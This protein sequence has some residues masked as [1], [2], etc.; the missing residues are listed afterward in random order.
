MIPKIQALRRIFPGP[1][2]S[3]KEH[4]GVEAHGN[5]SSGDLEICTLVQ[6]AEQLRLLENPR[7]GMGTMGIPQEWTCPGINYT[8]VYTLIM[9]MHSMYILYI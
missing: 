8:H 3:A 2:D 5:I 9:Y 7:N 4:A 1:V 6:V